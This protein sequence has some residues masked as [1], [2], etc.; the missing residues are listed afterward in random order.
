MAA[1]TRDPTPSSSPTQPTSWPAFSP[2]PPASS[3][4]LNSP[5][6]PPAS[7][8]LIPGGTANTAGGHSTRPATLVDAFKTIKV[9]DLTEVHK[10]P[11]VREALMVGIAG[12]FGIGGARGIFGSTVFSACN[13]ATLS[14][15]VLSAGMYEFCQRKRQLEMNSIKRATEIMERKK[16]EKEKEME[17]KREE[18]RKRREGEER[19]KERESRG[20]SRSQDGGGNK[21]SWKFW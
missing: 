21:G 13:F 11:C 17:G 8:N 6:S 14:F 19:R 2:N 12:G 7:A 20:G 18:R 15:I 3:T 16:I 5:P 4:Q 1:D 10:K 9:E